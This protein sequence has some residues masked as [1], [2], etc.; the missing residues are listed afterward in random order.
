MLANLERARCALHAIPPDLPRE[1]WVRAGMAAQSAG[2]SFEDF[3]AWSAGADRYDARAARDVWRSLKPGKGIGAGTLFKM[4]RDRGWR[5]GAQ[6]GVGRRTHSTPVKEA[7]AATPA[8]APRAGKTARE[9]W[10]RC[11]PAPAGHPYITAKDGLPAGLRVVPDGDSL[12]IANKS[13]AGWLVVPVR[14]LTGGEPMSLQ[15]VPPP[16]AGTK[17]NLP[18]APMTGVFVV[19]ALLPGGTAHLCEGIGQAWACWR[20]TGAAAVVCFGWGRVQAVAADMHQRDKATRL[21]LVP[22][23]GKEAEAEVIARDVGGLV[24]AMPADWERNSDVNDFQKREGLDALGALLASPRGAAQRFRLLGSADL[25][26]MPRLH[27]LI[28]GVLPAKGIGAIFGPSGSGKSFLALDMAAAVAEG[29]PWF[30]HRVMPASVVYVPLEGQAGFRLR[31]R[32]WEIKHRRKLPDDLSFVLQPFKLTD[33][34]DVQDMAE[35]VRAAGKNT[36]VVIDTLNAAAPDA[37]ENASS[38]MG[39][40]VEAAKALQRA[41]DGLVVMVHHTGKDNTKGLRGHSSLHAALDAAI[42]VLRDGDRRSWRMAKAKDGADGAGLAFRLDTVDIEQ[43]DDGDWITSCIVADTG[44]V[45]AEPS[46][47]KKLSR[48]GGNQRIILDALAP[49]FKKDGVKGK[50]GAPQDAACLELELAITSTASRLPSK[51]H[52][53]RDRRAESAREAIKGLV[54][55]QTLGCNE[56]W[57][58]MA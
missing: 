17:L 46:T 51:P 43:D 8:K 37:D 5:D 21:V 7:K 32:A 49:M 26:A 47:G 31:V 38:G 44:P 14:P 29:C 4:A 20:A 11:M 27:W 1:E 56:G 3:D 25:H 30:G 28:R 10:N 55:K 6:H 23:V 24:A 33:P 53:T 50:D 41:T 36:V 35:A 54:A 12:R 19:G 13:V 22:D 16:G 9:I 57:I 58:W 45:V 42:E 39:L 34:K 48:G 2:L 52:K 15:F 18:G 40:I